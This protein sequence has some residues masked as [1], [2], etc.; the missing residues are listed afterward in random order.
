MCGLSQNS[1]RRTFSCVLRGA[2]F[3]YTEIKMNKETLDFLNELFEKYPIECN[4]ILRQNYP[5]SVEPKV[6]DSE[7]FDKLEKEAE[8][9]I[10]DI[11]NNNDYIKQKDV[12]KR[13][14]LCNFLIICNKL[15]R[16]TWA[17]I[18]VILDENNDNCIVLL[19]SD[20]FTL[21]MPGCL[22]LH[23]I[24][25][26]AS[27]MSIFSGFEPNYETSIMITYDLSKSDSNVL[28]RLTSILE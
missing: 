2:L 4:Y 11:V 26:A 19:T 3:Y 6:M 10:I 24:C 22:Y 21:G 25:L 27:S 20:V 16:K 18:E 7:K 17:E 9:S 1:R 13:N 28:E 15:A 12:Q 14:T 23:N 8:A 5:F